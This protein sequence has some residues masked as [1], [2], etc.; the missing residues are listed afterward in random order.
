MRWILYYILQRLLLHFAAIITVCGVT[1]PH[2]L[3]RTI[4]FGTR[5]EAGHELPRNFFL[6]QFKSSF[7]L[8]AVEDDIELQSCQITRWNKNQINQITAGHGEDNLPAEPKLIQG[9]YNMISSVHRRKKERTRR[10]Q[11]DDV[12]M[13]N[14]WRREYSNIKWLQG[15]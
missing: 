1:T 12:E 10:E 15:R 6:K 13:S 5:G 9:E 2:F 8:F 7:V 3:P 14:V 11:D 4:F